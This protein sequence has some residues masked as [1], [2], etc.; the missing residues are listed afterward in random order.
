MEQVLLVLQGYLLMLRPN[1][2]DI[3]LMERTDLQNVL[4][5]RNHP[6]VR[7]YMLTQHEISF[8]EHCQW[9]ERASSDPSC[10]LLIVEESRQALGFVQFSN[11]AP[12][13]IA[14]WGFYTVPGAH[15]GTGQKLGRTALVFAF[16]SLALHKVCGQ[17]LGFNSASIHF[18]HALGF[19]E[20]GVLRDQH[21]IDGIY[22]DLVCFGLLIHEWPGYTSR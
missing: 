9:F 21:R 17:A 16:Q 11:V 10:R 8:D 7:R 4:E 12:G 19:H 20:E 5:W 22:H 3:R 15:R 13:S 1:I 18:H 2:C 14:D 6:E